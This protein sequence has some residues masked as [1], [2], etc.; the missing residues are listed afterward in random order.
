MADSY[1]P[2]RVAAALAI[3][4]LAGAVRGVT[5]FGG[6]LVMTPPLAFLF[7]PA[8]AVPVA[9]VLESF[10]AA[11]MLAQTRRQV[12]WRTL[13]PILAAECATVPLGGYILASTDPATLRRAIAAIVI[14]FA[15]MLLS[16]WRYHGRRRVGTSVALGALS[17]TMAGATSI[18]GPP[19]IL[20]LLAGPDPVAVT[21]ANLTLF[22]AVTSLAALVALRASGVLGVEAVL[23]GLALAPF[24]FAGL[25]A[26]ARA[27][28]RFSD[29]RF[30][31]FTLLLL[32]AVSSGI[33]LA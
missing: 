16:G 18:G 1:A 10:A 3:A 12:R 21:R 25:L 17:G 19:G 13:G 23:A 32:V 4:A 28:A 11:P 22:V 5:G 24:Y 27:F 31:R 7:G 2:E 20:Y 33:L 15:L 9:L 14:A 30:R 26:G 29:A 8:L 6:A